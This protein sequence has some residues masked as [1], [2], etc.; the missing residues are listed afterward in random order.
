M[1]K[2]KEIE[3]IQQQMTNPDF[4]K[5]KE[6]AA[7]LI[8]EHNEL[9]KQLE[10]EKSKPE[11][12]KGPYDANNA[13]LTISAGTGGVEACDW[14]EMLLRMYLK[15]SELK[16]FKSKINSISSAQEAGIKSATIKVTGPFAFGWLKSESGIHRLVRISPFDADKARHTSFALIEVIPEISESYNIDIP[17]KDLRIDVFKASGHGG[18]H[19]NT[20][21]SAV[22]IT[23]LP[24]KIVASCQNERSQHQNKTEAL[25]ALKSRL[26]KLMEEQRTE[27][28]SEIRIS[29]KG[30]G[31]GAQVRSYILN[32][33]KLVKDHRTGFKSKD[34]EAVLKGQLEPFIKKNLKV[35]GNQKE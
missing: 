20:T 30:P 24:T 14:A 17:Q 23:H 18:Q 7:Q 4:W 2:Q 34:V 15:F 32:P 33:Y 21:D 1:N 6:K 19:V 10:L 16:R 13:L 27:K 28:L 31:W 29:H 35:S 22:R 8:K 5:N 3:K 9:K 25:K 11:F 26:L 12:F